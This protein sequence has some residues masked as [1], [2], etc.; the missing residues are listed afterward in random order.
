MDMRAR[1]LV[2]EARDAVLH[3]QR[4]ADVL[5]NRAAAAAGAALLGQL[6]R[7]A[8]SQLLAG[9]NGD[10]DFTQAP[11][12]PMLLPVRPVTTLTKSASPRWIR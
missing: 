4:I 8:D 10:F 5:E 3:Q 1:I 11:R 7:G 9:L 2:D 12:P 6:P